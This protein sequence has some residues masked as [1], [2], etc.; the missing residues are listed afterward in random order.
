[1]SMFDE[2]LSKY[3]KPETKAYK[4][5]SD[6]MSGIFDSTNLDPSKFIQKYWLNYQNY[7]QKLKEN[8]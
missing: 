8:G 4:V 7:C 1:M 2:N 3:V 6:C 5:I